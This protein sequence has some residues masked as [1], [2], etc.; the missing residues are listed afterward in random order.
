MY[1]LTCNLAAILS[2]FFAVNCQKNCAGGA[3]GKN[4]I[5]AEGCG[6]A[7]KTACKALRGE[8]RAEPPGSSI[9]DERIR[10]GPVWVPSGTEWVRYWYRAEPTGSGT[11]GNLWYGCRAE[12]SGSG[13][14][15]ERNRVGPVWVPSGTARVRYGCRAEPSRS[16]MGAERDRLGPVWVPSGTDWVRY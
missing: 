12:P 1:T 8:R 13:M 4:E 15:A 5:G 14:G 3:R 2:A 6:N 16:G 7:K 9:G 11:T 10:L